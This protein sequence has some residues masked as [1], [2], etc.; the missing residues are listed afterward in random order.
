[1]LIQPAVLK[2]L[3]THHV[4]LTPDEIARLLDLLRARDK[5]AAIILIRQET[6]FGLKEA[7]DVVDALIATIQGE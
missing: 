7:K 4:R 6:S 2:I 3:T 5:I 1:M